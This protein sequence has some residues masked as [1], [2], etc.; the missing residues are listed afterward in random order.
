MA[1][2]TTINIYDINLNRIGV[3]YSWVSMVWEEGYNTLG[4][5]QLELQQTDRALD[6]VQKDRYC[7][8]DDSDTLMYI[9]SVQIANGEILVNGFPATVILTHRVST[10]VISNKNAETS[11]RDLVSKMEPWEQVE[12]GESAGL[13][14]KFEPQTSD[15]SLE[16]YC[17]LIGAECDMGFKFVHDKSTKTLKFV[18]YKPDENIN[19]KYSTLYGNISDVEYI[20]SDAEY[21]NVAIVAGAG[22]DEDR[23][24]VIAG[25][26]SSTG[27]ER[28]EVYIDARNEQPEEEESEEEYKE[29]LI[30]YGEGELIELAQIESIAFTVHDEYVNLGDIVYAK[31]PEIGVSVKARVATMTITSEANG[32]TQAITIGEPLVLTRR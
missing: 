17:E 32:T 28:R 5:F 10:D 15:H 16:E 3:L 8:I 12:L 26:T 30:A 2:V 31:I 18:C 25:A 7:G 24:T 9:E 19:A 23:I 14:D 6:L 20:Q 11:M 22:E 21:K 13:D 4:D 27:Y 1:K 29:R